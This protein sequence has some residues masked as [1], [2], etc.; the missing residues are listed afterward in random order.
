[1]VVVPIQAVCV[2]PIKAT[3]LLT[4]TCDTLKH[5]LPIRYEIFTVPPF[6]PDTKPVRLL[7]V[8]LEALEVLQVP[9][10]VALASKV[11]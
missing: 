4:V 9:P 3:L 7:T 10:G 6:M 1:M 5:V 8:A 2:P 11:D